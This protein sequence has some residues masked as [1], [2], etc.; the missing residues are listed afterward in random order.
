MKIHYRAFLTNHATPESYKRVFA[1]IF[2]A[3]P[4]SQDTFAQR[5]SLKYSIFSI[6]FVIKLSPFDKI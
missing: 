5:L 2:D 3:P 4:E 1:F 6:C